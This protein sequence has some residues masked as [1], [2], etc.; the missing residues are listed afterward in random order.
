MIPQQRIDAIDFLQT[1]VW[2]HA[3]GISPMMM[4]RTTWTVLDGDSLCM[5]APV[6]M[7]VGGLIVTQ[8]V[9]AVVQRL[10]HCHI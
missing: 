3:A 1:P 7:G 10:S 8:R 5:S 4:E 2:L 9:L 6:S